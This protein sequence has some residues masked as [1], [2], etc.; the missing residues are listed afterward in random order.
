M[1]TTLID[2]C[3]MWRLLLW[4]RHQMERFSALLV[5]CDGE[6]PVNSPHKRQWRG[7]L[8][9]CLICAWM[10]GW[11]NKRE[12]DNLRRHRAHYHVT[13]M[14]CSSS[15]VNIWCVMSR[16]SRVNLIWLLSTLRPR[17]NGRHFPDDIFECIFLNENVWIPIK[18][19]QWSFLLLKFGHFISTIF[20]HWFR[21]WLGTDQATSHYLNQWYI[22]ASLGLNEVLK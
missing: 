10:N 13:V 15:A 12:A 1:W 22:Y 14:L 8:M 9:F 3:S 5:I 21:W 2:P 11:A 19:S 17:Q 6:F 20:Q 16:I 7:A 18:N 4:W